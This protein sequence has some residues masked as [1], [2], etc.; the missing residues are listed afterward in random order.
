VA[1]RAYPGFTLVELLIVIAIL[2]LLVT[3]LMP[4]LARA[5]DVAK[6]G[7]CMANLHSV[8][9]GVLLYRSDYNDFIPRGDQLIWFKAFL[10]Y[11]GSYGVKDYRNVPAYRCPSFP[12]PRQTVCYVDNSWTFRNRKDR[13]GTQITKTTHISEFD[14]PHSTIYLA[15]N[16]DGPWRPI[17]TK[18]DDPTLARHDVWQVSHLPMSKDETGGTSGRRVARFRHLDGCCALFVD[19]H[20]DY[21]PFLDENRII[22]MNPDMWRDHWN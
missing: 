18:S 2:G 10:P 8:G 13:Y 7:A 1:R 5:R 15:D 19:G 11:V 16:E 4:T 3:L 20:S 17:V 9:R 21:V 6:R 14:K 12:D 22:V